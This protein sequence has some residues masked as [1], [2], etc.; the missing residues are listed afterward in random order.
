MTIYTYGDRVRVVQHPDPRMVS[1][2]VGAT[3]VVVG[4]YE[5]SDWYDVALDDLTLDG[6]PLLAAYTA[7]ELVPLADETAVE[8]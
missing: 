7:A 4:Y 1:Y 6:V 5:D 2:H 3:G 8:S